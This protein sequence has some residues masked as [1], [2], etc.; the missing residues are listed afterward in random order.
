MT[1]PRGPAGTPGTPGA[2][3][4]TG[5]T[6]PAGIGIAILGMFTTTAQLPGTG[7][8]GEGYI[9]GSD[10]FVWSAVTSNWQNVGPIRGPAGESATISVGATT[11]GA[12]GS[13]A[14]V[15]MTGPSTNRILSFR[16]PRSGVEKF[17]QTITGNNSAKDFNISHGLNSLDVCVNVYEVATLEMVLIDVRILNQSSV[18]I[19]FE[20]APSASEQYRVVVVG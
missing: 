6:G 3:G 16:L 7:N 19:S 13:D 2:A 5:A 9:I 1:G 10:L 17:A 8:V 11:I 4:A 18:R 14:E 20:T 15:T 12:H